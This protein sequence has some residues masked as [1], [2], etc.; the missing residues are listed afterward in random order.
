MMPLISS[1]LVMM[2]ISSSTITATTLSPKSIVLILMKISK[3]KTII[4]NSTIMNLIN[5][6]L[7]TTTRRK[8]GTNWLLV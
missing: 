1:Q 2:A 6:S 7:K 8:R 4:V 5:N 3:M